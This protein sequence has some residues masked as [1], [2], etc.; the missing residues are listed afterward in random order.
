MQFCENEQLYSLKDPY[1]EQLIW[2]DLK[3][4]PSKFIVLKSGSPVGKWD[5]TTVIPQG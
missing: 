2:F 3:Y 1:R 4:K 5:H